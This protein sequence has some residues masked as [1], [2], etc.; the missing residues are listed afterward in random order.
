ML[1]LKLSHRRGRNL[2]GPGRTVS[3]EAV[4]CN[5]GSLPAGIP[6]SSW[7]KT[8]AEIAPNI[9]PFSFQGCRARDLKSFEIIPGAEELPEAFFVSD[10]RG[11]PSEMFRLL[12]EEVKKSNIPNSGEEFCYLSGME[13]L[14]IP[15]DEEP[16]NESEPEFKPFT[17][18]LSS[19]FYSVTRDGH[20]VSQY[21]ETSNW[22][23]KGKVSLSPLKGAANFLPNLISEV[24]L[25]VEFF[26]PRFWGAYLGQAPKLDYRFYLEATPEQLYLQLEQA[27]LGSGELPLEEVGLLKA[28]DQAL[29]EHALYRG[30]IEAGR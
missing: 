10:F 15:A 17:C 22:S 26:R 5:A 19:H 16:S 9:P 23:I 29:E 8:L 7:F 14:D 24:R 2:F 12:P 1:E 30:F 6:V 25:G 28:L 4:L 27:G 3:L 11:R 18:S 20:L 13:E 21:L